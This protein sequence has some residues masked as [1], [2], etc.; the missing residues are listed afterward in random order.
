MG[1]NSFFARE[2]LFV[3]LFCILAIVQLQPRLNIKSYIFF[4]AGVL[5]I[6]HYLILWSAIKKEYRDFV[7]HGPFGKQVSVQV[8]LRK[9]SKI[10]SVG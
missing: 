5:L 1:L 7:E 6:M 2:I 3:I 9:M 8:G 10:T 4:A